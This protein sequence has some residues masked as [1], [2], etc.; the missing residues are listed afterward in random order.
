MEIVVAVVMV[1]GG[2]LICFFGYALERL[3][4]VLLGLFLGVGIGSWLGQWQNLSAVWSAVIGLA[5]GLVLAV[6]FWRF[7]MLGIT[8]AGTVTGFILTMLLL[9]T[10][11]WTAW[12][13]AL[14]GAAAGGAF[15]LFFENAF[16]VAGTALGGA[17]AGALG[18]FALFTGTMP[19]GAQLD[20]PIVHGPSAGYLLLGI[21]SVAVLGGTLQQGLRHYRQQA[22]TAYPKPAQEETESAEFLSVKN[23]GRAYNDSGD[24]SQR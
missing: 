3:W 22:H 20:V 21:L 23:S 2:A 10:M 7:R 16:R 24:P 6:L 17:T 13:W 5:V 4:A 1:M 18:L 12:G 8:V 14:L 9:R 15:A 19:Y 11:E